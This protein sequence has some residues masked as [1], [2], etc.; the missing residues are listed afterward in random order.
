MRAC[1]RP[2]QAAGKNFASNAANANTIMA[3]FR[4][5]ARNQRQHVSTTQ[6][7][8]QHVQH[9]A[10]ADVATLDALQE[11]MSAQLDREEEELRMARDNYI[12]ARMGDRPANVD[13][14]HENTKAKEFDMPGSDFKAKQRWLHWL[15][16]SW[17]EGD[18]TYMAVMLVSHIGALFAPFCFS[19]ANFATFVATYIVT[20]MLGI[21]LSYHRN[22]SHKAFRLPKP[23]EHFFAY[24]GVLSVQG[25]PIEWVSS[26]RHH[27]RHCDTENDPHT[28]YEGLWWSHMG[29][30]FDTHTTMSRVS[31]RSNAADLAADPFYRFV[32]KTYGWHVAASY[33]AL[34]ILGGW[35]CVVWGGFLRTVW[36]YHITWLVNSASHVW[37][38]QSWRTG[39]LSR[40]NWWVGILAFGEG[41][42]NNHHAFGFSARHGLKWFEFDPTW[43]CIWALKK[44]G[45]ATNV[46]LPTEAQKDK[47]RWNRDRENGASGETTMPAAASECK[48]AFG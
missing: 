37:G 14:K 41:W 38:Y 12:A 8:Q 28:P 17:S 31:D 23:L 32:Q 20:G 26:H 22:L 18:K 33:I 42:H 15:N 11:Q 39:D 35:P 7:K 40:N 45:L 24:C 10:S 25:D 27:H 16:R 1:V 43:Y 9:A 34:Y 46:K 36:V 19:W 4:A 48:S 29:W 3:A 5:P 30:L 6:Q 47:L 44:L 21:T 13:T 2:S